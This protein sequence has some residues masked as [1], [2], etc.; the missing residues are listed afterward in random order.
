MKRRGRHARHTSRRLGDIR[1]FAIAD[2]GRTVE[3]THA[4]S[5]PAR[6]SREEPHKKTQPAFDFSI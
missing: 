6:F 5:P 3:A 4:Q 2:R 1:P